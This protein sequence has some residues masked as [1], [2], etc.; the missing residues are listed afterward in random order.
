[1][2][3][4]DREED[5][6]RRL[7]PAS[8]SS[9]P[10]SKRGDA[11]PVGRHRAARGH[12][13]SHGA[14]AVGVGLEDD[15]RRAP[16][17]RPRAGAA[18]WP[19]AAEVDLEP[20]RPGQRRRRRR[21]AGVGGCRRAPRSLGS[22][23]APG[24]RE[25][26]SRAGA[27]HPRARAAA[28]RLRARAISTGGPRRAGRR[29]RS[30]RGPT[31]RPRR[32]GRRP[33][34]AAANGSRPW[35]RSAP[36]VPAR[37]SPVPARGQG[38]VLERRPGQPPVGRGDDG[39]GALEDHDLAPLHGASAAARPGGVI[40]DEVAVG[41]GARC[42]CR[43]AAGRTRP[44][45]G[46][47]PRPA[48]DRP[49]SVDRGQ[50]AECLGVDARPAAAPRRRPQRS[51]DELDG[52]ETGPQPGT[53]DQGVVLVV[54]DPGERRPRVDLLDVVLGQAH[55]RRLDD[56]RGEQGLERLG[57]GE[58]HEA[59]ARPAP[60]RGRRG[61]PRRRSRA[62]RRRR[63]P[64]RT[65]PC[66]REP[67]ARAGARAIVRRR[68][69]PSSARR[70]VVVA[71]RPPAVTRS[72]RRRPPGIARSGRCGP[73]SAARGRRGAPRY[74]AGRRSDRRGADPE[75]DRDRVVRLVA[76]RDGDPAH[77]ELLGARGGAAVEPDRRLAGRQALDL[78]LAPADA[79]DA[80]A[81]DLADRL[82]GGPAAGERLGPVADVGAA[83][84]G[85]G[86]AP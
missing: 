6:D 25:R 16:P 79:P 17:A 29:R 5:E 11:E 19:Q 60:R 27:R 64:C 2:L 55:R 45:A 59:G 44:G 18:G 85:S 78:D 49:T 41:I 66:G 35:A 32:G 73:G 81:E 23:R 70:A 12:A 67:A 48:D 40:G 1:M 63:A 15:V 33:S 36:I 24:R 71:S 13:R 82:L 77:A 7:E 28:S 72:A 31:R 83:P 10:S 76:D 34:R 52:R 30:A 3:G 50:R 54:E 8:R 42:R 46:S 80:E 21:Q 43:P 56:L 68:A 38:R 57:H 4:R 62:S 39:P 75:G 53:D 20:G 51:P 47:G 37:T 22:A 65:C 74:R 61:A 69:P 58:G 86:P 14:V 9:T 84:R 26:Q